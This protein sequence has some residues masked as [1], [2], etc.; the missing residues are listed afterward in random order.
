MPLLAV[1]GAEVAETYAALHR[2]HGVEL[3]L[4]SGVVEIIGDADR[5]TGIRLADGNVVAADTIVIGVGIVPNTALADRPGWRSTTASSSTNTWS[6]PTPTYSP[7]AMSPTPTTRYWELTCASSTG[8][9]PSTR[10]RSRRRT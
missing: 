10:D 2:D 6:R 1:L 5:V 4:D 8:R 3:R 7:P 9:P